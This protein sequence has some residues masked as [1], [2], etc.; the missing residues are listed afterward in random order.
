PLE[1]LEPLPLRD[2]GDAETLDR[3]DMPAL[4]VAAEPG[5][6]L[7]APAERALEAPGPEPRRP[8]RRRLDGRG[9]GVGGLGRTGHAGS[10][11]TPGGGASSRQVL[12]KREGA[13]PDRDRPLTSAQRRLD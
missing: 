7:P 4:D 5:R 9:R 13:V 12:Q 6:A 10:G 8:A 3:R 2:L 11:C 1:E